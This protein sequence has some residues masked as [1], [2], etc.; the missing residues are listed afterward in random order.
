MS[1]WS[2][3]VESG[4]S[5]PVGTRTVTVT[6]AVVALANLVTLGATPTAA[7]SPA[8]SPGPG[9]FVA[10]PPDVK[11]AGHLTRR[12]S[13]GTAACWSWAGYGAGTTGIADLW[14]PA[15]ETFHQAGALESTRWYHTATLLDDDSVAIIG[16]GQDTSLPSVE[17]W[18]E[19]AFAPGGA[20]TIG[21]GIHT[22]TLLDDGTVLVVGGYDEEARAAAER[23][24]PVTGAATPA[25]RLAAGR[26]WHTATRLADGRVLI[27]GGPAQAELWDP[28]PIPSRPQARSRSRA[29]GPRR[30]FLTM[31]GCSSWGVG[32]ARTSRDG[33]SW[34]RLWSGTRLR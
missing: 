18:A 27:V 4:S 1:G 19:G 9:R 30:R 14:D 12:P 17:T 23:W 13:C 22:A 16:G 3:V 11:P 29:G 2:V 21:R 6:V 15:T 10:G 26:A 33:T 32:P 28:R 31:A 8:A 24:D 5:G 7:A 20:V 25:G 34:G